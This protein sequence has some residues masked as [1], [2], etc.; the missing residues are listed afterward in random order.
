MKLVH[1]FVW[2][3]FSYFSVIYCQ[4]LSKFIS[5]IRDLEDKILCLVSSVYWLHNF[6]DFSEEVVCVTKEA[7]DS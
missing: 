7:H 2:V 1:S 6:V 3:W 5:R 4:L